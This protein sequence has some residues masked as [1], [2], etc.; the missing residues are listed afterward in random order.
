[1]KETNSD[2]RFDLSVVILVNKSGMLSCNLF[3]YQNLEQYLKWC[4]DGGFLLRLM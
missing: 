1:M 4:K 3:S 2:L